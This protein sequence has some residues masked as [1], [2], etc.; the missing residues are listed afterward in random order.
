M[1]RA[2]YE[3]VAYNIR[4]IVDVVEK[5]FGFPLPQLRAIG[6]GAKSDVWMQILADVTGRR[7][8]SV[9]HP[10]EG[11][12]VGAALVAAVGLGIYPNF[13]ALKQVV[14]VER[15]FQPQ[16][17]SR[18]VYDSLYE[19]YRSSYRSLRGFYK[20]VSRARGAQVGKE[21]CG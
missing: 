20:Q 11:G 13:E 4:W 16:A 5:Q 8:E 15:V 3:G 17:E 6:G 2:V 10:Q 14:K 18:Q 7:V 9:P 19:L 21:E 12:A 1:L